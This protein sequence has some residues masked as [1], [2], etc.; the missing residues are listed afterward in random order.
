MGYRRERT[1]RLAFDDDHPAR[2]MHG[3]EATMRRLSTRQMLTLEELQDLDEEA[4]RGDRDGQ[5]KKADELLTFISEGCVAWNLE[6]DD[7]LPV[8][9]TAEA[10]WQEDPAFWMELVKGWT[11]AIA[12]VSGPLD[13]PPSAGPQ[14]PAVS[15]PMDDL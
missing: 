7:G 8:P 11:D 4:L 13:Q 9:V 1:V 14:S 10:L 12:G 5:R 6:G 15:I 2:H 3:F